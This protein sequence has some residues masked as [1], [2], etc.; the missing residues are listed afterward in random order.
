MQTVAECYKK[1]RKDCFKFIRSQEIKKDKFINKAKMV[2][3]F[4]IPICF[5]IA[6]K[7]KN[8][9]P[10]IVG[11]SG[12]QGTGKTTISSIMSII[13]KKYF[14]LNIFKISIDDFYKTRKERFLLSKKIHNLLKTRGVPGTH[15][16]SIILDFLNKV[17]HKNFKPLKL[18]KF[19]K[20]ADDRFKK[21][22]WYSINKRPDVIIFEGWCIGARPQKNYQLKKHINSVEKLNDQNLIWRK[23]V[24]YQLKKNYRKLFNQL[25][26]LLYLKAKNFNLLQKWR[27]KQERKLLT[28]SR[29]YKNLK[30]MNKK[31]VINFMKTYER[32]TENMFKDAPKYAS[33]ILN[34]NSNHQ[35]KSVFYKKK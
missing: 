33:I 10:F 20:A 12:G 28:F 26:C 11:L 32:I 3:Y 15:D 17:K 14:K 19:N 31:E 2:K 35:I 30:V 13:L 8:R 1:V 18:P 29:E 27:L 25:N 24:N 23:Y 21:E 4:L 34:L 6:K 16:T 22:L 7:A 5:W 9:K